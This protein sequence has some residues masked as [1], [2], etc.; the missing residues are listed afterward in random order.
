MVQKNLKTIEAKLTYCVDNGTMPIN[1]TKDMVTKLPAYTGNFDEHI[2]PIQD[3][4]NTLDHLNLEVN[5]FELV[6]HITKVK[7]FNDPN[8][9]KQTYYTEI[10]K[11]VK[12][13]TEASKIV[14][15]DH[16][17]RTGNEKKRAEMFLREPVYRVHNDY[18]EWSGPQRVRDILP[19]EAEVLLQKR[20]AV[21]QVWRPIQPILQS[22]P[23]AL[24]DA[25]SVHQTDLIIA[26]RR[27]P[28]RVGQTYQI[29]YN[30]KHKWFYFPEMK[31]DEAIIFK[32]YDSEKDGR[33]RFTP[34]TSFNDPTTP[35]GAL[36]RES[37]ETRMLVFFD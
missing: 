29:K 13:H 1:E 15:F 6:S 32:V 37:I 21:I 27:Y 14:M 22:N 11:L 8:E 28:G 31:S 19:D 34:H 24:C 18:T 17:I 7:N 2:A 5:G 10:K 4:R 9:I 33:A 25:R 3:A 20:F 26:E 16:T 36:P 12:K 35:V 30:E 23:L